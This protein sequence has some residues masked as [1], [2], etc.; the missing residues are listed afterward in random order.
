M[1]RFTLIHS[2]FGIGY[3]L[4]PV[5]IRLARAYTKETG[6][7]SILFQSDWDFPGLAQS[8]G[9]SMK[10]RKCDHRGTDGTVTC[11]DCGKTASHFIARA[12]EYLDKRCDSS[13]NDKH[14]SIALYFGQ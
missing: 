13:F 8:L 14:G 10:S 2:D 1:A 11:P 6:H 5:S 12:T 7:E 3:E 9:W 4:F